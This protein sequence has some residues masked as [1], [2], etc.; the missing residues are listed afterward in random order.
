[1]VWN[2][3]RLYHELN[4]LNRDLI[5]ASI[6]VD[7][8]HVIAY[9]LFSTIKG[10]IPPVLFF[11]LMNRWKYRGLA[12]RLKLC[13][14]IYIYRSAFYFLCN[15][16]FTWWFNFKVIW[17]FIFLTAGF[18]IG[19][20]FTFRLVIS[21][22]ASSY[23]CHPEIHRYWSSINTNKWRLITMAICLYQCFAWDWLRFSAFRSA[24][25]S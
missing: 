6:W 10:S 17:I 16:L 3:L 12:R 22:F 19:G 1:M 21:F 13:L 24:K 23:L 18:W 8:W 7:L 4:L 11:K 14:Y 25:E 15:A 20:I 9:L 5:R 2:E